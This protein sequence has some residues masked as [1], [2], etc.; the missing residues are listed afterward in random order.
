VLIFAGLFVSLS[1][2]YLSLHIFWNIRRITVMHAVAMSALYPLVLRTW[3]EIFP[4]ERVFFVTETDRVY[5]VYIVGGM[6]ALVGL[7]SELTL[8]SGTSYA[9]TAVGR[10][11]GLRGFT[12][13][14]V[15]VGLVQASSIGISMG[16]LA[17]QNRAEIRAGASLVVV[18]FGYLLPLV[19]IA[20]AHEVGT[21][22]NRSS[23]IAIAFSGVTIVVGFRGLLISSLIA[24]AISYVNGG[25]KIN[26]K[27]TRRIG[28]AF[29][30]VVVGMT[31][32]RPQAEAGVYSALANRASYTPEYQIDIAWKLQ[33]SQDYMGQWFVRELQARVGGGVETLQQAV[34][35]FDFPDAKFIGGAYPVFGDLVG[36]VGGGWWLVY[37][38]MVASAVWWD[39]SGGRLARAH[40]GLINDMLVWIWLRVAL[41][42]L[43]AGL[44]PAV[45]AFF[46]TL[47]FMRP[48][49][50]AGPEG[51]RDAPRPSPASWVAGFVKGWR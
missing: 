44:V 5:L 26:S 22:S 11:R 31:A 9:G 14:M 16:S 23:L 4:H 42:G 40:G 38:L 45:L 29:V 47:T 24:A 43:A 48:R 18:V 41:F 6:I 27:A 39:V 37:T 1:M 10:F 32:L 49:S 46:F 7:A 50:K 3:F 8:G 25:A 35:R 33:S 20:F 36:N 51:S 34:W 12:V 2:C 15:V 13:A 28:A 17:G 19:A 21:F 30:L